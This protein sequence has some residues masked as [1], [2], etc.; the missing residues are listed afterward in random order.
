MLIANP[1]GVRQTIDDCERT[2]L[3]REPIDVVVAAGTEHQAYEAD[4]TCCSLL[5]RV[6]GKEQR[7]SPA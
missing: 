1:R 7:R 2:H 4:V 6:T 5:V 3:E